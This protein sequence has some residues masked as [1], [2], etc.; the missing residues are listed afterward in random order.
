[1]KT[2]YNNNMKNLN[3]NNMNELKLISEKLAKMETTMENLKTMNNSNRLTYPE[4][5][6]FEQLSKENQE[7]SMK[8]KTMREEKAPLT[9]SQVVSRVQDVLPAYQFAVGGSLALGQGTD[10]SDVDL[11][12]GDFQTINKLI[13]GLD[14]PVYRGLSS[15][16]AFRPVAQ[17]YIGEVKVDIFIVPNLIEWSVFKGNVRYIKPEVVWAARGFYAGLGA[18]KA[19]NQMVDAGVVRE[20]FRRTKNEYT[21]STTYG[22]Y[23]SDY[24]SDY[25]SSY[26]PKKSSRRRAWVNP[27]AVST[28]K[29]F[30]DRVLSIF[31]SN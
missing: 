28:K 16:H 19:Q 14:K 10:K 30:L 9:P 11:I 2:L 23:G 27:N 4:A 18:M 8:T 26:G 22:N 17:V 5:R 7:K 25:G 6:A 21:N 12:V 3:N 31:K 1:M 20:R 15:D 24:G 29:S 13:D